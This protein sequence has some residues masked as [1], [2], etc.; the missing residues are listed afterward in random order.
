LVVASAGE[1]NKISFWRENG[2][3]LGV[4]PQFGSDVLG[5][6]DES[7]LG[8][9]FSRKSSRYLC[10]G[11][12]GKVVRV[13]DLQR[14]RCIKWLK[15]HTD[16]ITGITY[17][18]KD[19][20]LASISYN[21]NLLLHNLA[22][23]TRATELKDPH[24]QVLRVLDYSRTSRHV[25]VTSGDEGSVHLWDT[26][27]R[28][29][30]VSWT[31]QHSAPTTGV[32][33]C[34]SNDKMIVSVGFDKK[35]YSFDPTSKKPVFCIPCEAPF[36]SLAFKDDGLIIAAGTYSGRVV[37]YD[38]RGTLHPYTILRA[39]G[40]TEE[41]TSLCWQRSNPALVDRTNCTDE[42]AL[43]GD[44]GEDSIL[45]PDPLPTSVSLPHFSTSITK[46]TCLSGQIGFASAGNSPISLSGIKGASSGSHL[47]S[48]EQTPSGNNLRVSGIMSRLYA[49]H[50]DFSFKDDMSVFSPLVDVQPISSIPMD[51]HR[52]TDK[53]SVVDESY[54]KLGW[55]TSPFPACRRSHSIEEI[56]SEPLL[57]VEHKS[58]S[59]KV[60]FCFLFAEKVICM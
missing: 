44:A 51:S 26:T 47:S 17:N 34:P 40:S 22:S 59:K 16:S 25:F 46:P 55:T 37:F 33:F 39:Y 8:I 36:T 31:K 28:S 19:E 56:K 24:A 11:G 35:L 41:V 57:N 49:S 53:E 10:S 2:Q 29:P 7:I 50:S 14:Q 48:G 15:G 20:Y 21:G 43:L 5:N 32:C 42:V 38:V 27:A 52:D 23:A 58:V 1:D 30:K 3:S 9:C 54:E 6:I 13:W 45:M 4:V 60:F 18:C 12:T